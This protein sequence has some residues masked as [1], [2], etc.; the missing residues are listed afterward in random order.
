MPAY[1]ETLLVPV[2]Q[3]SRRVFLAAGQYHAVFH[4]LASY[5][6]ERSQERIT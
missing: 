2:P 6:R 1:M 5:K 4:V 3:C